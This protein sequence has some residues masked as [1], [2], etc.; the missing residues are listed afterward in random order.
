MVVV[1]VQRY[2]VYLADGQRVG[3]VVIPSHKR[4]VSERVTRRSV[5]A[6]RRRGEGR[7]AD[8]DRQ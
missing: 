1:R 4:Q 7:N 6:K 3:G 2:V 8:R 5:L